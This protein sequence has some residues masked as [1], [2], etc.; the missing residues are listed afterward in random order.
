[1]RTLALRPGAAGALDAYT[2]CHGFKRKQVGNGVLVR[3]PA[4][5]RSRGASALRDST[6]RLRIAGRLYALVGL[7]ALGCALLTAAL[8]YLQSQRQM[9]ARAR[10]LEALVDSA[11]GVFE[12]HRKLAESGA[13]TEEDALKR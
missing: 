13:M 12:A 8:V 7:F 5:P 6:M 3:L 10:E 9:D 4:R 11:I 2:H 1:M